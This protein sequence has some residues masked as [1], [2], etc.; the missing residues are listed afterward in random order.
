MFD[1]QISSACRDSALTRRKPE[2]VVHGA[3]HLLRAVPRVQCLPGRPAAK[4][5]HDELVGPCLVVARSERMLHPGP[6][7]GV[8]H[9]SS[10]LSSRRRTTS[11]PATPSAT[12]QTTGP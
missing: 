4:R 10:S 1:P 12:R 5:A 11:S 6:E 2:G 7:L 8:P 3:P 9:V